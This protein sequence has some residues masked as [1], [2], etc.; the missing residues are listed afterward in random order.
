MK[1]HIEDLCVLENEI[2]TFEV[3]DVFSVSGCP[4]SCDEFLGIKAYTD[5]TGVSGEFS[6]CP[7]GC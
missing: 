3:G 6:R 1:S 2:H 4:M 7:S 5:C